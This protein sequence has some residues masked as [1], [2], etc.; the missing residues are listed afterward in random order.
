MSDPE[1]K[2]V[3]YSHDYR[4]AQNM[5][6]AGIITAS[7]ELDLGCLQEQVR[8]LDMWDSYAPVVF[9]DEWRQ[10]HKA[11]GATAQTLRIVVEL[12]KVCRKVR[13]PTP[14]FYK[15]PGEDK[16]AAP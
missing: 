14:E 16:E 3:V 15:Y 7:Y 4:L 1:D 10:D 2:R 12:A 5:I 13:G 8:E 11:M 9:P 6:V